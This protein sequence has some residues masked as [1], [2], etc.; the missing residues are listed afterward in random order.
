MQFTP[1]LNQP[2]QNQLVKEY[3]TH[4]AHSK[5]H[6]F[7]TRY[8]ENKHAIKVTIMYL[9]ATIMY[10]IAIRFCSSVSDVKGTKMQMCE[11]TLLIGCI[12]E[13]TL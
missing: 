8:G 5:P 3:P 11:I 7:S 2:C 4:S 1:L 9:I 12:S 6:M 13:S 10:L